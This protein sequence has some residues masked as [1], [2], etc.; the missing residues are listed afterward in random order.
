MAV[1]Q[2]LTMVRGDTLSFDLVLSDLDGSTVTSIFFTAKKKA[3]DEIGALGTPSASNNLKALITGENA[4]SRFGQTTAS[5]ATWENVTDAITASYLNANNLAAIA[6]IADAIQTIATSAPNNSYNNYD[7]STSYTQ[8]SDG[9]SS[10]ASGVVL[11][12]KKSSGSYFAGLFIPYS[13]SVPFYIRRYNNTRAIR[14][15]I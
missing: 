12:I 9:S 8:P 4:S 5:G 3:T 15:L 14:V 1:E 6:A 11:L 13:S 7:V 10:T 2:N